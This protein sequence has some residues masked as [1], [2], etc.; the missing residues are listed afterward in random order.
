MRV[1][2]AGS[3]GLIGSALVESLRS[4]GHE[5][6]RLVRRE[7]RSADEIGW[8][9][10]TFGVTPDAL[11]G[12]DAVVNLCGVGIGNR[13]WSG[14]FKQKLRDSRMVPTQVLAE[15][16]TAAGVPVFVSSSATGIYGFTSH[17]VM[18]EQSPEGSGFLAELAR[19]WERTA[20]LATTARVALIRTAPVL[21]PSGGLLGKLRPLFKL[22]LGA[23]LGDG[24]QYMSWI[25][26]V[27][28]VRAVRF[29]LDHEISGPVNLTA[30]QP[31]TNTEFTAAFGRAVHR[32]AKLFVPRLLLRAA[33]GELALEML[34]GGQRAVPDVL[35]DN[36]F[37][38][39]H[40]TIDAGLGYANA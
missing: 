28:H 15:A 16:I 7:P 9:P 2:V 14:E 38:F 10:E 23:K 4:D 20:A 12:V 22:G 37:E 32:P 33:A 39:E 29:V 3:S 31:V 19:D 18:T 13:P 21:S 8:S 11:D 34:L 35:T 36:G 6:L 26:L 5:V 40:P 1:A 25:S 17:Q 27:D 24:E 30:P